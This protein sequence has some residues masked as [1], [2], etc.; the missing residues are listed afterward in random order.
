MIIENSTPSA[1]GVKPGDHEILNVD[2]GLEN[3]L[4]ASPVLAINPNLIRFRLCNTLGS[5]VDGAARP[6]S[7]IIIR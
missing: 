2:E 6:Y 4:Q 1:L 7:F 3:G 5:N